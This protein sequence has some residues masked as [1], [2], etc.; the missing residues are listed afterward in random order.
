MPPP[1]DSL[2]AAAVLSRVDRRQLRQLAEAEAMRYDLARYMRW[3]WP[4][5]PAHSKPLDWNWHLDAKC[6]FLQACKAGQIRRLIINEPPRCLKSW[7]VSVAFPSW[8][9]AS[10]PWVQFL[11]ASADP[12]VATRDADAL[13]DL[14][15]SKAYKEMFRPKWDFRGVSLGR[16]QDAKGYYRNSAGGHRISKAMGAKA[17]G[18]NT[19]VLIFDDPLDATDAYTDKAALAQHVVNAKQK[20]MTRLNDIETGVIILIMQRLHELDLSGVFLEDGGWE[21]LYLPAEYE[22]RRVWNGI[23]WKDPRT[24]PGELLFPKRLPREFLEEKKKELGSR[25]YAGQY[26]QM[27]APAAGAMVLKEWIQYWTPD[28]LPELTY[29]IGSWDPT[30]ASKTADADYVVGQTWG[31]AGRNA[32][33]LDQVR[34]KMNTPEMLLAIREQVRLWPNMRAIVVEERAAGKHVMNTL[35]TEGILGLQGFDPGGQSKQER[36]FATLPMWEQERVFI[37]HHLQCS[38]PDQSF[39]WVK[40]LYEPE[41][42]TFPG[43]RH[44]DQVDA[45][46]QALIWITANGPGEITM[47]VLG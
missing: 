7:T 35:T 39:S 47:K 45:T 43:S 30:F 46:S 14:C 10:E 5:D 15:A 20:F 11:A 31:V 40:Q 42:L 38:T 8:W 34:R 2:E 32:Y 41:L 33:L 37:P 36:L 17:Q 13:R 28:T 12:Q 21:H 26:Q 9:W 29:T 1:I 25:G 24:E 19:D 44:D 3:A 4:I 22:G 27:P 6:E 18:A 23:G 16:Q